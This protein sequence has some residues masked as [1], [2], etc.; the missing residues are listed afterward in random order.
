MEL[1]KER[2]EKI[3]RLLTKGRCLYRVCKKARP[4]RLGKDEEEEYPCARSLACLLVNGPF[5]T[6]SRLPFHSFHTF[7]KSVSSE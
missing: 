4:P 6:F 7:S 5:S 2:S 1:E 3:V